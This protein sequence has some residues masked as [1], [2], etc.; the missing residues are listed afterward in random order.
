MAT[1]GNAQVP[2]PVIGPRI[3]ADPLA[4]SRTV[5]AG[6]AETSARLLVWN[7]TT[8]TL[9][10]S[11]QA[12]PALTMMDPNVMPPAP[13]P[14]VSIEP[15]SG[16]STGHRNLHIIRVATAQLSAGT[17]PYRLVI[18]G[19][20][21][22][23]PF[24]VPLDVTIGTTEPQPIIA[25]RP[26]YISATVASGAVSSYPLVVWN[27]GGG[28][29]RYEVTTG[30][31]M[32]MSPLLGFQTF[33][34]RPDH[35]ESTGNPVH[36][37]VIFNARNVR[38]GH[39]LAGIDIRGNAANSP[40][41]LEVSVAVTSPTGETPIIAVDP[42]ELFLQA[43]A[44][45]ATAAGVMDRGI[46]TGTF[47]VWNA[48]A[49]VLNYEIT[50][51]PAPIAT[52]VYMPPI[53][54]FR[55]IPARG[56]S[57]G[58]RNRHHVIVSTR[59]LAPG[60][61]AGGIF[62]KGNASNSP[63][64]IIVWLT[65]GA[66]GQPMIATRPTHIDVA[67]P[68]GSIT[69]TPLVVWNSGTGTLRYEVTTGPS[70]SMSPL[71]GFE[72]FFVRP[73]RGESTGHPVTHAV[74]FNARG[75]RP[76][77]YLA[78]INIRG[79]ASNSPV[80]LEV[81]VAVTSPTAGTPEIAVEPHELQLEAPA[82]D[83]AGI[84]NA[85]ITSGTF[86]VWNAGTGVLNYEITTGP[87]PIRVPALPLVNFRVIPNHGVSSGE[88]NR[89]HVIVSTRGLAPGRY[90]GG[91]FVR[92]NASNAP[93]LVIVWLTV[94]TE[95][96]HA[97]I[98]A[99]PN[100]LQ[101]MARPN[102]PITTETLRVWNAGG[103]VLDYHITTES[104]A[105]IAIVGYHSLANFGVRPDEG[106]STGTVNKHLVYV[107]TAGLPPGQH[108]GLI[109]IR[110]NAGNSP[111]RVPLIVSVGTPTSGPIIAAEPR[112]IDLTVHAGTEAVTETLRIRNAGSGLLEYHVTTAPM[113][114]TP[115][116]MDHPLFTFSVR[117]TDG[118]SSGTVN[119]HVVKVRTAGLPPG[120]YM[121]LIR[122]IG[123]ASNSPVEVFLTLRIAGETTHP[124]A[125]A[126]PRPLQVVRRP[127]V[128]I[129]TAPLRIWNA[130][131]GV[132]DY[133][134]TTETIMM[135]NMRSRSLI[136]YGVR[137][138]SG[139][140][141][142]EVNVHEVYFRTDGL[143]IGTYNGIIKVA[144]NAA[145]VPLWVP[146]TLTINSPS[147]HPY[148]AA[149]PLSLL[150]AGEATDPTP[151]QALEI[152]NA[153]G[154]IL[155]Y[156]I[157][158][159]PP[160]LLS[161]E[162]ASGVSTGSVQRHRV[163]VLGWRHLERGLYEGKVI[164]RGNA[165]NSP[166]VIPVRVVK[167][168]RHDDVPNL[169]IPEA[170]FSPAA[171]TPVHW[172]DPLGIGS[173]LENNGPGN[174][175]PFWV[176]VWGSRLGGLTL[177]R[178]LIR[179]LRIGDGMGAHSFY[180]W[181][182]TAPMQSIPDGPY[183]V[184]FT[185]D[186]PNE[187]REVNER[188]NRTVV[189]GKRLLVI[190][191]QTHT[192]LAIQGFGLAQ[193]PAASGQQV[194]FS[195]TVT[196]QGTEASG[197]FWI[198]FWGST[199][200]PNPALSF[201]LCDSIAIDN[202]N[203]GESINLANYPRQLYPV[204]DG[205]FTIGCFVDR[206]DA[207]SE[208][209]EVNNYQFVDGQTFNRST[210]LR[211]AAASTVDTPDIVVT[212]ADFAPGTPTRLVPGDSVT[213]T[214]EIA[215]TGTANTGPFWVEFLG[216]LNGG[217]TLS[218]FLADSERIDNLAPGQSVRLSKTKP[219]NSIADGPYT[220][221]IA[222]DRPGDVAESNE[223]NNR[224]PVVGKRLLTVRPET[225]ANLTVADFAVNPVSGLI[226]GTVRNS[227]TGHS[228]PFWTEFWASAGDPDYPSLQSYICNSIYCEDLGPGESLNIADYGLVRAANLAQGF[229]Y[230][231]FVDRPDEVAEQDEAD[232]YALDRSVALP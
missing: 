205:L 132:L 5:A 157:V 124:I 210:P 49:G 138:S 52:L 126:A 221:V 85:G 87:A 68:S 67:L 4:I 144:G 137:P 172:G 128:G 125:A 204:P 112:S 63:V 66:D 139:Q 171:P 102:A 141:S 42:H 177:D 232:N 135:D 82:P 152:R 214:F 18:R 175:G 145:N 101:I 15:T 88:R 161:V 53:E 97:V 100:P 71:P 93:G 134:V 40:V 183:T 39:Y 33:A 162:P 28:T 116:N 130:G 41:H 110:G 155:V 226:S 154:G 179:S 37:A 56:V 167:G 120:Y 211:R 26:G 20:A 176:E 96:A 46:T 61:Y 11:M 54:N 227:G 70:F 27:S 48:G 73:E 50:T 95:P 108:H 207:I 59:G 7:A 105:V 178:F 131:G 77:R 64:A 8:G 34:V 197:P 58:E 103:G 106:R 2:D 25:T 158:A 79:N 193:N 75:V 215:N 186:R 219:L 187:V 127:D 165:A 76:G 38:P 31:S 114:I 44:S 23:S 173:L 222:A 180:S 43:P 3:A 111:L 16:V 192:D 163:S 203:A 98:A 78:G 89:H 174:A 194:S 189:H 113:H 1:A 166:V 72:T 200:W 9:L 140:S 84:A 119:R 92:G 55:V 228:G 32:S 90:A 47:S 24:V 99:A 29:L 115:M 160:L 62:V 146:V 230:V 80:H 129:T 36:H 169:L 191:P 153:G 69:S 142:G 182:T 10:Y 185:V 65:I 118:R 150:L 60:H 149:A 151:T 51:G 224:L 229:T 6:T 74:I 190:R 216:S 121:G 196:N 13:A 123:N 86:S 117:P 159:T 21:A 136:G 199:E 22:N 45:S 201:F 122:V 220:V 94:G 133:T 19:N 83:A 218:T 188:D 81:S 109:V 212:S 184:V 104:A 164:I 168:A 195:G 17:H 107:R 170:D 14:E 156:D 181:A 35:G 231:C 147:T 223:G 206:D 202:L 217:L 12:Y 209:D 225:Q 213:F 30:P 57:A 148:I 143:A 208:P 198:E 91:I